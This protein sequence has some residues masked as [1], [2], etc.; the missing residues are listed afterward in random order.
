[1][2]DLT[3]ALAAAFPLSVVLPDFSPFVPLSH[4]AEPRQLVPQ[5]RLSVVPG[6]RHGLPFSHAEA[7]AAHLARW[8]E[9]QEEQD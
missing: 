8:L 5:S 9:A 7:E 1:M 6:V 2:S 4:G 3:K